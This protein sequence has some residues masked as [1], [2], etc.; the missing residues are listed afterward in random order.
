LERL[1]KGQGFA[2]KQFK[3]GHQRHQRIERCTE[4]V[5]RQLQKFL[6]TAP[7]VDLAARDEFQQ[8]HEE[9]HHVENDLKHELDNDVVDHEEDVHHDPSEPRKEQ[10]NGNH[11]IEVPVHVETG[12]GAGVRGG[13][14]VGDVGRAGFHVGHKVPNDP[15]HGPHGID[16]KQDTSGPKVDV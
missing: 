3:I 14:G 9:I 12:G 5:D 4:Q 16:E 13:V 11:D 1:E 10:S 7:A 2:P 8:T 6:E 15:N